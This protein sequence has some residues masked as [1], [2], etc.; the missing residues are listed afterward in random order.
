MVWGCM[1]SNGVDKLSF[2]EATM[3]SKSY[4]KIL[5]ENL[6]E[7]AQKLGMDNDFLFMHD[8]DPKHTS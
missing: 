3:N 7:S 1:L 2:I 8:N 4:F 6:F 5:Q